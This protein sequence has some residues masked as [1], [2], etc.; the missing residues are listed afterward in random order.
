MPFSPCFTPLRRSRYLFFSVPT[1]SLSPSPSRSRSQPPPPP[2]HS[3]TPQFVKIT[4][5]DML[6]HVM[7]FLNFYL[8]LSRLQLTIF[9][10]Y[11]VTIFLL[12]PLP[13]KTNNIR[14][15]NNLKSSST[16]VLILNP[17]SVELLIDPYR[18]GYKR[19]YGSINISDDYS[20]EQLQRF[21]F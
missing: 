9:L 19:R 3:P 7:M 6:N 15:N 1:P 12:L 14:V 20:F 13:L 5:D 10:I 17:L 21:E 18:N 16:I 11:L 8:N 2:A 4:T